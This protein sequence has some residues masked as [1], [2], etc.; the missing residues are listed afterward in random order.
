MAK[1]IAK[2]NKRPTS[3]T[4][5]YIITP[6]KKSNS[7]SDMPKSLPLAVFASM[8]VGGLARKDIQFDVIG[9]IGTSASIGLLMFA[10]PLFAKGATASKIRA[11]SV[12]PLSCAAHE[13]VED[14][15]MFDWLD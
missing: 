6:R 5:N 11:A 1:S 3:R 7:S 13:W 8:V 9:E 10:A 4:N 12:G 2:P 15:D 14:S